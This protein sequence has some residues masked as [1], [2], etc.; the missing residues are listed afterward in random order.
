MD[1]AEQVK[2]SLAMSGLV[3]ITI[4][5]IAIFLSWWS[6]QQFRFDLFLKSPKSVP[7]KML[8][9]LLSIVLGYEVARFVIDYFNWSQLLQG[10]F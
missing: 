10:M 7:A 8:Q 2:N 3:N 5:L 1:V 9:V 4:V 6:L